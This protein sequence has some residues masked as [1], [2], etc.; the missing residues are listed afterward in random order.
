MRYKAQIKRITKLQKPPFGDG[1][2]TWEIETTQHIGLYYTSKMSYNVGDEIEYG[3]IEQKNKAWKL[4][5]IKKTA[6]FNNYSKHSNNQEYVNPQEIKDNN[7]FFQS[8]RRDFVLM[9][10][11]KNLSV[12][13]INDGGF[14]LYKKHKQ[15]KNQL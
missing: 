11:G 12:Q 13:E 10:Q 3:Y 14:E 5:G 9:N 15:I 1:M 7:I 8:A 2:Y 4:D 6:M